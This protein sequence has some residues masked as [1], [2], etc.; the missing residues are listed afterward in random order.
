VVLRLVYFGLPLGALLLAEDGHELSLSVLS[1]APAPGRRRL[2]RR[3][4]GPVLEAEELSGSRERELFNA[5]QRDPPALLVSW[6]WSR[7]LEAEWLH[8]PKFAAF[9]VH[10]SLLPRHRG[11]DPY[12]WAIDCGDAE[13]GVSAHL[14]ESRYDVGAVLASERLAVGDRNAW[15]LARALDR[16]SLR[17]MRRVVGQYAAGDAPAAVA[18]REEEATLAPEPSGEQLAI[19]WSWP[20]ARVLRRIRA[21]SPV[22]GLGL[23]IEGI[24]FQVTAARPAVTH[25][26][27]LEPGEAELSRDQGLTLKTVDGAFVVEQALFGDDEG[28]D[29]IG[30]RELVERLCQRTGRSA[31]RGEVFA[32]P[33]ESRELNQTGIDSST[34][35]K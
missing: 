13:T 1:P 27:S 32:R 6:F 5:L 12:F 9:G 14:L 33:S 16:P 21:L 7:R 17:L 24:R 22:P 10:P 19:D 34:G 2:R 28:A 8:L 35:G 15:Q 20:T 26:S 23:E 3:A 29:A 4:T 11:P 25:V 30:G 18:Q 31:L